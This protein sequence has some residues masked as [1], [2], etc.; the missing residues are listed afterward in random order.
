MGLRCGACAAS[1]VVCVPRVSLSVPDVVGCPAPPTPTRGNDRGRLGTGTNLA[2]SR[3]AAFE[4]TAGRRRS[5]GPSFGSNVII[6]KLRE[7][8]R[9]SHWTV[10]FRAGLL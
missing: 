5:V 7:G 8:G 2:A 6:T 9:S 4:A 3:A 10:Q 1:L